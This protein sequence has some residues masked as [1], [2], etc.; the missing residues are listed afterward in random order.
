MP[1]EPEHE[2]QSP[3][4]GQGGSLSS[5]NRTTT[6]G[7]FFTRGIINPNYPGF[8]HFAHALTEHFPPEDDDVVFRK[9]YTE[10]SNSITMAID[11]PMA[12]CEAEASSL[13]LSPLGEP[14]DRFHLNGN[15]MGDKVPGDG[16]VGGVPEESYDDD[17][18]EED[19]GVSEDAEDVEDED[20]DED[21][22]IEDNY[23][24]LLVRCDEKVFCADKDIHVSAE[25]FSV[26][27]LESLDNN[28]GMEDEDEEED[29]SP[30]MKSC[31]GNMSSI[32]ETTT[33][34][35]GEVPPSNIP[36]L[37]VDG[38]QE[39]HH[40]QPPSVTLLSNNGLNR[41]E[42]DTSTGNGGGNYLSRNSTT[43]HQSQG[44][45]MSKAAEHHHN[46][47]IKETDGNSVTVVKG[48]GGG[49]APPEL[50]QMTPDILIKNISVT[51]DM[52]GP[53]GGSTTAAGAGGQHDENPAH[54]GGSDGKRI[55]SI[56]KCDS[57]APDL[58]RNIDA[59]ELNRSKRR[60]HRLQS[61]GAVGGGTVDI[62]Q[63]DSSCSDS[64]ADDNKLS[65]SWTDVETITEGAAEGAVGDVDRRGTMTP[66]CSDAVPQVAAGG[67]SISIT[68]NGAREMTEG[69]EGGVAAD[70]LS[71]QGHVEK[72]TTGN[73]DLPQADAAAATSAAGTPLEHRQAQQPLGDTLG[74]E[75]NNLNNNGI[76][77]HSYTW[78]RVEGM[79]E[80]QQQ[81]EQEQR[82]SRGDALSN[83]SQK[84]PNENALLVQEDPWFDDEQIKSRR[85]R[86]RTSSTVGDVEEEQVED[87]FYVDD[88]QDGEGSKQQQQ[89]HV[90]SDVMV[91][92]FNGTLW[93]SSPIDIV[94]DFEGEIERELGL[95]A[96][97]HHHVHQQPSYQAHHRSNYTAGAVPVV[98]VSSSG[99][100]LGYR[101]ERSRGGN[102][103][104]AAF[105]L[106]SCW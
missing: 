94:G 76:F 11:P 23:N 92:M 52:G 6:N 90:S 87:N 18:E 46:I 63:R 104:I 5:G 57:F 73:G 67:N 37:D 98:A 68:A 33:T 91:A 51:A 45:T 102:G 7:R 54:P 12:P 103:E 75:T 93:N 82:N 105:Q 49:Q 29:D 58:L 88:H 10:R 50:I 32:N 86:L 17:G 40:P 4:S 65:S 3:A 16:D 8:Q 71:W 36:A 28:N 14:V 34:T 61:G 13:Q 35:T 30:E 9:R 70:I 101:G 38:E 66:C 48:L 53:V 89:P 97:Q 106:D 15:D 80:Q 78:E 2:L 79:K 39:L 72:G 24:N 41:D 1:A 59:A 42:I 43:Q 20:V 25:G 74:A 96:G 81:D 56:V 31:C 99:F 60:C 55:N 64:E 69:G 84:D 83:E 47:V 21:S 62:E 19:E 77:R 95:I 100:I 26:N 85:N 44:D 27:S 22:V